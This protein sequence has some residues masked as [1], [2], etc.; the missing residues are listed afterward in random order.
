MNGPRAPQF[1]SSESLTILRRLA[2][3]Q[4]ERFCQHLATQP[5]SHSLLACQG[6][7]APGRLSKRPLRHPC[8]QVQEVAYLRQER[9]GCVWDP[10]VQFYTQISKVINWR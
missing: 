9:M 7:L 1:G 4:V 3:D 8:L 2:L 10:W 6:E 5:T